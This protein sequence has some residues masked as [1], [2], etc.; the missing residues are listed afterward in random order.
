[1]IIKFDDELIV[2]LTGKGGKEERKS[3]YESH[4]YQGEI[5]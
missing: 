4:S 1:M 5:V 3:N 2:R